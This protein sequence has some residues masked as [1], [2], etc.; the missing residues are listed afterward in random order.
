VDELADADRRLARLAG[1]AQH[2]V[3]GAAWDRLVTEVRENAL[4]CRPPGGWGPRFPA[5]DVFGPL[6]THGALSTRLSGS[7]RRLA[8]QA[9]SAV[10]R[11]ELL[12]RAYAVLPEPVRLRELLR[13]R[14]R[15]A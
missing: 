12:D 3:G 4:D 2:L 15:T 5:G 7:L 8:D 11:G 6:D 13:G 9:G 10:E 1:P 14:R